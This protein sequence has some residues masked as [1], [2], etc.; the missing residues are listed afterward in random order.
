MTSDSSWKEFFDGHAS[1]YL[2][3]CFTQ[4]T[5]AELEFL[6]EELGL[7]EGA[8]ILDIGC[9]VG[10]HAIPL[11]ARGY[12]VTG[13]DISDGML[14]RARAA[15]G[16]AG[17]DVTWVRAD[18]S[19]ELPPGPF[20]AAVCLCE[21]AFGLL[22]ADDDPGEHDLAI[23]RN[24]HAALKPGA[25]IVLTVLNAMT[26][27]RRYSDDDVRSGRFDPVTLV[28]SSEM[29]LETADGAKSVRVRERSFVP[30]EL[31][32]MLRV[33]GFDVEHIWGGT[34]GKWERGPVEL[35]EMEIMA[36]ARKRGAT[37]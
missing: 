36:V 27:I 29:D 24:A 7:D 23:L 21:G 25:P 11:A 34:A 37:G 12:R 31:A 19:Q 17:V 6:V 22:G 4:N 1:V 8:S 5:E 35:D 33:A 18:V 13:V 30:P 2:E 20:D 9:G 32:L 15:A 10:R 28:E 26:F 3:N 14:E 16:E